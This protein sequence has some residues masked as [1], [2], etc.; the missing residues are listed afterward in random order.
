MGL[1]DM[2]RLFFC[3]DLDISFN[4]LAKIFLAT[5]PFSTLLSIGVK[6]WK[7]L[8]FCADLDIIFSFT[9]KNIFCNLTSNTWGSRLSNMTCLSRSGHPCNRFHILELDPPPFTSTVVEK[10]TFLYRKKIFLQLDLPPHM[11]GGLEKMTCLCIFGHFML[12]PAK[13]F[14]NL[15]PPSSPHQQGVRLSRMA[16]LCRSVHFTLF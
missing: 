1:E 16:F 15:I 3:A 8:L 12:F 2:E 6:V 4:S 7:R 11:G 10:I 14:C 13:C 5:D 9:K